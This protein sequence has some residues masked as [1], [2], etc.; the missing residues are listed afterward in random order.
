VQLD[1]IAYFHLFFLL[2]Q[3]SKTAPCENNAE[4]RHN[5]RAGQGNIAFAVC[6]RVAIAV[7]NNP[8][9]GGRMW[10]SYETGCGTS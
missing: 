9:N 2:K 4:Y 3:R 1:S 6:R 8:V 10:A 5:N 7:L